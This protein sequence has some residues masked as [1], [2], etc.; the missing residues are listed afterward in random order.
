MSHV[1]RRYGA[2]D[3]LQSPFD[4]TEGTYLLHVSR[5][6]VKSF[7]ESPTAH[8]LQAVRNELFLSAHHQHVRGPTIEGLRQRFIAHALQRL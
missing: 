8:A 3:V 7:D 6:A 1:Q 5:P 2:L 4:D